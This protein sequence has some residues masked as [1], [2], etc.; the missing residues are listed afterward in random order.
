MNRQLLGTLLLVGTITSPASALI[1]GG[2]AEP[3]TAR[4]FPGGSLPLANLKTRIAWW[5]GPP[6]GGGQY[7]FEYSGRTADLQVAIDLFHKVDSQ[8]KQIVVR[9]GVQTSFWLGLED[10]EQ[11]HAIDWQFVVWVPKNWEH[12]G[13]AGAGLLP[14]GEEGDSPK[15]VLNVFVTDR[16][17]WESLRIPENLTVFDERLEANGIPADQGGALRGT[18]LDPDGNPIEGAV[19]TVSSESS[20]LTG[21]SQAEGRFLITKIPVG[22]HQIVFAADGFASKAAHWSFT[23]TTYREFE[24]TLARAATVAVRV[25]DPQGHP[26]PGVGIRVANCKDQNGNHYRLAGTHQFTSDTNGEFTVSDVPQ[27]TIKF[28]S[29]SP[30]YFYNPVLNE[31]DTTDAPIVLKLQPT[32]VVQVFVLEASGKPI[33]SK[34]MVEI[35]E[36][37][38]KKGAVGSWGGSANIGTDGT[39]TFEGIPPGK[40]I[41]TGKPNP[42]RIDDRADPVEVRIEG[43]DRHSINLIAK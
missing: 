29:R 4:G 33:T 7:H 16:I 28:M 22:N 31:H 39:F 19:V 5:E 8:R 41:V 43:K 37:G 15:T 32:G 10:K 1:T 25:V 35:A 13:N 12:L 23:A 30:E 21:T 27:G 17:E 36:Q 34:Y 20:E 9:S 2:K 26:L 14:P 42:G 38:A 24:V 6:F 18:V 40:Y 11:Q 3:M